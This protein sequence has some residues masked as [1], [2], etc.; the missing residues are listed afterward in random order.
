MSGNNFLFRSALPSGSVQRRLIPGNPPD[1]K[2]V[3]LPEILPDPTC[4]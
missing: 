3:L 4:F 1:G 2:R